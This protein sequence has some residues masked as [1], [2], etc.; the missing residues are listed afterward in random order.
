MHLRATHLRVHPQHSA[1]AGSLIFGRAGSTSEPPNVS[2]AS[3]TYSSPVSC[4]GF[5]FLRFP[6]FFRWVARSHCAV[7]VYIIVLRS[8]CRSNSRTLSAQLI[9]N[10]FDSKTFTWEFAA[11][12]LRC[13]F[14]NACPS[15]HSG[16]IAFPRPE[17]DQVPSVAR[18]LVDS[19]R[20]C[21]LFPLHPQDSP[22][23]R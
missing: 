21:M 15:C 4:A 23:Y 17:I 13:G 19:C 5:S 20:S 18:R 3:S 22:Q 6:R 10:G 1:M 16:L 14:Y 11:Q 7:D 9:R 2:T 8:P 12:P